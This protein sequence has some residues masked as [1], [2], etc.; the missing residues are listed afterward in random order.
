MASR[1]KAGAHRRPSSPRAPAKK[2]GRV[3]LPPYVVAYVWA[4][5]GGRC[6][7]PSCNK[8]LWKDILTTKEA[9]IGKL[10]HIVGAS[11][12]GPRGD[13]KESPRLAK[14]P[15]NIMLLCGDHHDLVDKKEHEATYPKE[16][17]R[18]YKAQH[19]LR[20]ERLTA[21][22]ENRTSIPVLV[23]I[24]VGAYVLRTPATEISLAIAAED[25]YPDD[26]RKVRVDMNGMTGRDHDA[27]FWTE[28]RARLSSD[29][30]RQ[31]GALE[32]DGP[33][34]HLSVFAFGPI[35]L[36]IE[37]GHLLDEK[38]AAHVHNRIH[39][40]QTWT[41]PRDG[42]RITTFSVTSPSTI[43]SGAE[44]ALTLSVTSQVQREHVERYIGSSMPVFE[45]GW[46][47]PSLDCLRSPDDLAEF[48]A[49]ARDVMERIHRAKASKVHVFPAV[50]V[51]GAVEF[52]R[53][54]QKKLHPPL[55]LHDFHRGAQGWRH[56]FTL[57]ARAN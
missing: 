56:A 46:T 2:K 24:P 9:N 47:N 27:A 28:A 22:T 53:S 29:L 26:T 8:A 21:I 35:P 7:F 32:H 14:D 31:L 37:L 15:S 1:P 20:I 16:I 6:E 45:L 18:A 33:L 36:L 52:G 49:G 50:P 55:V 41:W 43:V 30:A 25:R 42:R 4:R 44:V 54:L 38:I 57:V 12:D 5:A 19:E 17:L 13:P 34:R 48:V 23:E 10:A 3:S 39:T 40:P 51:A 11:K